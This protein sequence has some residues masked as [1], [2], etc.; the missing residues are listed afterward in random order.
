[1]R[2]RANKWET[3]GAKSG[4]LHLAQALSNRG[5]RG[6]KRDFRDAERLVKRLVSQELTLSFVPDTEQRLWRSLTRTRGQRMRDKVR[7]QNQLE[8]LLE[9]AIFI[10]F[11]GPQALNG[12]LESCRFRFNPL[13]GVLRPPASG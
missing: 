6:R 13:C 3:A 4:T 5:R 2:D 10:K 11:R 1:V 12:R 9:E 8:A 7:L